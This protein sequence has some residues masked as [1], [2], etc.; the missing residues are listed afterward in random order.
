MAVIFFCLVGDA[1]RIDKQT[2]LL[3][4][5][6][7]ETRMLE[8]GRVVRKTGREAAEACGHPD[9]DKLVQSV[10]TDR[11][12]STQRWI[13]CAGEEAS[14]RR[15][16]R[17]G[18]R[19]DGGSISSQLAC[20]TVGSASR[21][22]KWRRN[23]TRSGCSE[24]VEGCSLS[25]CGQKAGRQRALDRSTAGWDDDTGVGDDRHGGWLRTGPTCVGG[26]AM[27]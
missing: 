26:R 6:R 15:E 23:G 3:A 12:S 2:R 1:S 16:S 25:E 19:G 9:K 27:A 8:A 7:I 21:L 14:F 17:E 10:E 4:D 5:G 22:V 24:R 13:Y 20:L 11:P 18:Q